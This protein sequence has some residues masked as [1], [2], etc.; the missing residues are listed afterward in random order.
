MNELNEWSFCIAGMY[1]TGRKSI[2]KYAYFVIQL[3]GQKKPAIRIIE[4]VREYF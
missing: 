1:V 4:G 3:D 2:H